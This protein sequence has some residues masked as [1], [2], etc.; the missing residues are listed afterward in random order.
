MNYILFLQDVIVKCKK[1]GGKR[2]CEE[3]TD[4]TASETEVSSIH[5]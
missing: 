4:H 1:E 2:Q 3:E 5:F